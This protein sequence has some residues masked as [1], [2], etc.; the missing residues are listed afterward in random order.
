MPPNPFPHTT[1]HATRTPQAPSPHV[2]C[3]QCIP[4][5]THQA[6]RRPARAVSTKGTRQ[7]QSV[8][9]AGLACLVCHLAPPT[10]IKSAHMNHVDTQHCVINTVRSPRLHTHTHTHTQ[11]PQGT[12]SSSQAYKHKMGHGSQ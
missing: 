1:T 6:P 4:H 2:H 10:S 8:L 5:S 3:A 9:G 12:D 11:R 7:R